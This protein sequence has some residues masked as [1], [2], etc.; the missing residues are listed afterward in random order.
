L[1]VDQFQRAILLFALEGIVTLSTL[2]MIPRDHNHWR[3]RGP[4]ERSPSINAMKSLR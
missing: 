4:H 3:G 1:V 2:T